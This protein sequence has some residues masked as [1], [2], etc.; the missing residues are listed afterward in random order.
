[1]KWSCVIMKDLLSLG[2]RQRHKNTAGQ[3]V[4]F[5]YVS[6]CVC[7]CACVSSVIYL[8]VF[9]KW[10]PESRQMGVWRWEAEAGWWTLGEECCWQEVRIK[11]GAY[12]TGEPKIWQAAF[13]FWSSGQVRRRCSAVCLVSGQPH[14]FYQA[15]LWPSETQNGWNDFKMYN[16]KH[17]ANHTDRVRFKWSVG[18]AN[19]EL[20]K[21][22][23]ASQQRHTWLKQNLNLCQ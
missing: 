12:L 17:Q 4:V 11:K 6:V 10:R 19:D 16:T 18:V 15:V 8:F 7:V 2:T 5:V 13:C 20:S 14:Y 23:L 1:M 22:V 21:L 3:S 9:S